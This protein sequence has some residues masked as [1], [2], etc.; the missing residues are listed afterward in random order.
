MAVGIAVGETKTRRLVDA[1][2]PCVAAAVAVLRQ[3]GG[4]LSVSAIFEHAHEMGL[5]P[6][7]AHN[8]IRG[9]LSQ[10][11]MGERNPSVV[12]LSGRRGWT[13]SRDAVKAPKRVRRA[14]TSAASGLRDY[15]LT[16]RR[17]RRRR[18]PA[19]FVR[20]VEQSPGGTMSVRSALVH[21]L[22]EASLAWLLK[23]AGGLVRFP[24]D[25]VD[26]LRRATGPAGR[27]RVIHALER[28]TDA[29]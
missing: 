20:L 17:M 22:D 4:P 24:E 7:S 16:P 11:V 21:D 23:G 15:I 10:H 27:A 14:R 5:L 13:L 19:A 1:E 25:V 18:A 12:P 8:T 28:R 6:A 26:R 3:V 29:A 9:R 2:H